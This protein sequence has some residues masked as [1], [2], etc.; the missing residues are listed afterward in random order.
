MPRAS[1]HPQ[2]VAMTV[3]AILEKKGRDVVTISPQS[4]I[5]DAVR[6]LAEHRIGAV[7]V[8]E[9]DERIAGILSERDVV[10]VLAQQ[11]PSAM[12]AP[13]SSAMTSRVKSC[14]ETMTVHQVM[15][16]MTQGRFRHLPVEREGRLVGIVSIGDVVKQRIEDVEREA[17]EIKH[18]I[19]SA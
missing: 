19:A 7:V 14:G 18:Y 9:T 11:G 8:T 13:V 6:A 1:S 15:E 16:I 10:R 5:V 3:K 17:D 12:E 4:R 2:E